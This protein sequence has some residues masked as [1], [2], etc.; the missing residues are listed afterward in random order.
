[1]VYCN[2]YKEEKAVPPTGQRA[3]PSALKGKAPRTLLVVKQICIFY[4][5]S[6]MYRRFFS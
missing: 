5:I 1:M 3:F 4:N 6:Y 2:P